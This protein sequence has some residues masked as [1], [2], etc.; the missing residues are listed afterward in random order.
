[1]IVKQIFEAHYMGQG[2]IFFAM[3]LLGNL[4]GNIAVTLQV[5]LR[6]TLQVTLHITLQGTLVVNL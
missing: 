4:V 3:V 2:F 6:I 1:M 5:S